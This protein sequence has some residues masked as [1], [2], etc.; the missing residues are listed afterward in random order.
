MAPVRSVLQPQLKGLGDL[1]PVELKSGDTIKVRDAEG[2]DVS[3][4]VRESR[5]YDAAADA[6]DVFGSN[7]GKA[8]LNII[9]CAGAWDTSAGQ[10][11]KRLVVFADKETGDVSR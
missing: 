4:V 10:Y 3:F 8:H 2:K 9:T 5:R 6:K 11:A 7:D 1:E